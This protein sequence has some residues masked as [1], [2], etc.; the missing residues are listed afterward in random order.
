MCAG[1]IL[2]RSGIR[3]GTYSFRVRVKDLT[4]QSAT[5]ESVQVS[6]VS[7]VVVTIRQLG[8]E[9]TTNSGSMRIGGLSAERLIETRYA[10]KTANERSLLDEL[11]RFLARNVYQ[12]ASE[13]Q[14]EFFSVQNHRT[15]ANT[16]D[17]R[18]WAHG[19]PPLT[20]ERL[21][22]LLAHHR[23]AVQ[24]W[25]NGA[26]AADSS[27]SSSASSSS[28]SIRILATGIDECVD[29]ERRCKDAGCRTRTHYSSTRTA[30]VNANQTA[31]VGVHAVET[32][33]CS[34]ESM[35]T[36]INAFGSEQ[37]Q[38]Q[39]QQ[40][41]CL[42][43]GMCVKGSHV[44]PCQCRR[45]FDGP[46]CQK[47]VRHFNASGGV[48][49]LW[50]PALPQCQDMH[51]ALEFATTSTRGGLLLYSGPLGGNDDNRHQQDFVALQL[52]K[53]GRSLLVQLRQGNAQ[54]VKTT[55][56]YSLANWN[57]TLADGAWHRVDLYKTSFK[58]RVTID[59]CLD[60]LSA[61]GSPTQ[62]QASQSSSLS[63]GGGGEPQQQQ[64]LIAGCEHEFQINT[65]DLF[66]SVNQRH[67]IQLG[68]VYDRAG[69][70]KA[71]DYKGA[72]LGCMRN[73][74]V[75]GE[76]YDMQVESSQQQPQ[77]PEVTT[78]FIL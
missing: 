38:A 35:L 40:C 27:S 31:F 7:T 66:L 76:L 34:C 55:H 65:H 24:Q 48:G 19:S 26:V 5:E 16:V 22:G 4:R 20:A 77:T 59:R 29:S 60:S 53:G 28:S 37:Q 45:G 72:F 15:L 56:T 18:F 2:V 78:F 25:L 9:A 30:L 42:N 14:L 17:V 64:Q 74:R 46:R 67:P 47:T 36:P 50:L 21:N 57:R 49:F 61:S 10:K 73:V 43:G 41:S 54:T 52:D 8:D 13:A 51:V 71:L 23:L 39:H 44:Q 12:L 58:Y 62:R 63:S 68:G 33:E 75:N 6:V 70:V 1:S 3:P 11:R 69:V 32:A